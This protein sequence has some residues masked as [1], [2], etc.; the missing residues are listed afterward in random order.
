MKVA[1]HHNARR[2]RVEM[3]P[4]LDVVFLLIVFFIYAFLSMS[5][6]QGLAV[7]LPEAASGV[8][9]TRDYLAVTI[10]AEGRVF[11]N[12]KEVASPDLSAALD[13][14]RGDKREVYVSADREAR[15]GA[16]VAV[17]DALRRE[18]FTDV[19]IET[20]PGP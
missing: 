17:L 14:W 3:I 8:L 16:V 2:A 7:T 13:P 20:A 4:L 18:G 19:A 6:R 12:K 11:L 5:V 9:D 10:D 1:A 15:H